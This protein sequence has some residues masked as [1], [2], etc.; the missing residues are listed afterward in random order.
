[1]FFFGLSEDNKGDR[2]V[3]G[4]GNETVPNSVKVKG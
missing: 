4:N 2:S 3:G 1:M